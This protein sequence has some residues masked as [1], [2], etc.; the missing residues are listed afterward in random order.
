VTRDEC[1]IHCALRAEV[2]ILWDLE[3][4]FSDWTTEF[5]NFGN[6]AEN[7]KAA[8]SHA[9]DFKSA[10]SVRSIQLRAAEQCTAEDSRARWV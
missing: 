3:G 10:W 2:Q 4:D 9:T 6:L 5:G 1:E 8:A 7:T